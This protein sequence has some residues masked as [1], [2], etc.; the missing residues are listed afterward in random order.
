MTIVPN[1]PTR[2]EVIARL[3][4]DE[5]E[6]TVLAEVI[7]GPFTARITRHDAKD[8]DEAYSD[9]PQ[10]EI[11]CS[12]QDGGECFNDL[13]ILPQ[14]VNDYMAVALEITS[15]YQVVTGGTETE[16][17]DGAF[18]GE[19]HRSAGTVGT[20]SMYVGDNTREVY[21]STFWQENNAGQV[22]QPYLAINCGTDVGFLPRE[23]LAFAVQLVQEATRAVAIESR[24]DVVA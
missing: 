17:Q 3:K 9:S 20:P 16:C 15:D 23:A 4:R 7:R 21:A 24:S 14:H 10:I 12:D 19:W 6:I 13:T 22:T 18:E 8:G 5:A 2:S 11:D 1:A